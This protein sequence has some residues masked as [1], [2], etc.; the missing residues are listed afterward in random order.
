MAPEPQSGR[1]AATQSCDWGGA[2]GSAANRRPLSPCTRAPSGYRPGGGRIVD[3]SLRSDVPS[4]PILDRF[5]PCLLYSPQRRQH[6]AAESAGP[7]DRAPGRWLAGTHARRCRRRRCAQARQVRAC[8]PVGLVVREPGVA[9]QCIERRQ[10]GGRAP[11][12]CKRHRAVERRPT[13]DPVSTHS[14]SYNCSIA[15][16][17]AL[18][19]RR[20]TACADCTAASN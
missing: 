6:S 3:R 4:A 19:V 1:E 13:G 12:L 9:S 20:R 15:A 11:C 16:Q 5:C 2:L 14:A 17:S 8:R 7:R 10:A 18:P